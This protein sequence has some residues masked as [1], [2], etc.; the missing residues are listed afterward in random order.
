MKKTI[1]ECLKNKKTA[2]FS[3][4]AD[5]TDKFKTG[6][7]CAYNDE[8]IIIAHMSKRGLYDGFVLYKMQDLFQIDTD[9]EYSRKIHRLYDL[10][11]QKHPDFPEPNG[12]PL[13]TLLNFASEK[14]YVVSLCLEDSYV[15]GYIN[16]FDD[17]HINVD[18][19]DDY[20]KA[21][22]STVVKI[23][24]IKN[25]FC[26]SYLEQDVKILYEAKNR[27]NGRTI[28]GIKATG[29]SRGRKK[30]NTRKS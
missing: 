12:D 8:Y 20:G 4:D 22:G 27:I 14:K 15:C 7:V 19:I 18:V 6:Y 17:I 30:R 1:E 3:F 9:N 24:E 10:K 25:I 5:N 21:D 16:D 2:N 11:N 28:K 13:K 23:S 29:R 26:D